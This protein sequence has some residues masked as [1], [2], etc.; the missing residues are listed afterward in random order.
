[1]LFRITAC[2]F[3]EALMEDRF[4]DDKIE[5]LPGGYFIDVKNLRLARGNEPYIV[6]DDDGKELKMAIV[7]NSGHYFEMWEN[8]HYFGLPN[9][10][11]WYNEL[12]WVINM[13]KSFQR[14]YNEIE[15]FRIERRSK[16]GGTG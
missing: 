15:S 7:R 3:S 2:E 9:G 16:I 1:M 5:P 8:F 13:L 14:I 11:G 4:F 12:P 10:K 6:V